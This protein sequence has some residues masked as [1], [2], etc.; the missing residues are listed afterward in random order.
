MGVV[1]E[2]SDVDVCLS[3]FDTLL[4]RN[5]F[6]RELAPYLRSSLV[7]V[8][9][10]QEIPEAFVP[11]LKFVFNGV[12]FDMTFSANCKPHSKDPEA[13]KYYLTHEI[14]ALPDRTSFNSMQG[15][16]QTKALM[17]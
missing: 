2:D 1:E 3:T 4:T 15:Y 5:Q 7:G 12:K 6:Y 11:L 9:Y 14:Y 17:E 16:V 8:D 10:M 13:Y